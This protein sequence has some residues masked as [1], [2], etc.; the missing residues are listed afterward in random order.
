M[1]SNSRDRSGWILWCLHGAEAQ[2]VVARAAAA[3]SR[4]SDAE[5][6][7]RSVVA[8][9]G[10]CYWIEKFAESEKNTHRLHL[11]LSGRAGLCVIG[12]AELPSPACSRPLKQLD[13]VHVD[14][15]AVDD[16][17]LVGIGDHHL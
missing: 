4:G 1:R 12:N 6:S 16:A 11:E 7:S 8:V 9:E 10:R 2:H 14:Q 13:G 5:P 17:I 3:E 15:A